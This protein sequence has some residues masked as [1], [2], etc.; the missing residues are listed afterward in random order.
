MRLLEI[1]VIGS[2]LAL[3]VVAQ[4][5]LQR[6]KTPPKVHLDSCPGYIAENVQETPHSLTADLVLA[7]PPSNVYGRDL[8]RL[9]LTVVY[10][11]CMSIIS[12]QNS[13]F[14]EL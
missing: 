6:R 1:A 9:K 10:E 14:P 8:Q 2:V 3:T 12:L 13:R 4:R 7:G 5:L 11:E